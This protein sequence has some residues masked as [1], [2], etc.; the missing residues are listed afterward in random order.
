MTAIN[1]HVVDYQ[2][3]NAHDPEKNE[4]E[5][6]KLKKPI[7][8]IMDAGSKQN[9]AATDSERALSNWRRL[10]VRFINRSKPEENQ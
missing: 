5:E 2:M 8:K 10:I 1:S 3:E 4:K 9:A 7:A 6:K